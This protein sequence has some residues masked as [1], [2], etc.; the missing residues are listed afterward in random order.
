[1][2]TGLPFKWVLKK[3]MEFFYGRTVDR[4]LEKRFSG[5]FHSFEKIKKKNSGLAPDGVKLL[6]I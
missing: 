2:K 1:M 3:K 6:I 5:R 4:V